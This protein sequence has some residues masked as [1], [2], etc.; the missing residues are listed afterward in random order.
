MYKPPEATRHHKPIKLLIFLPLR[1][2]LLCTLHYETPCRSCQPLLRLSFLSRVES[3]EHSKKMFEFENSEKIVLFKN[4]L[5]P[6]LTSDDL[7]RHFKSATVM[8][9]FILLYCFVG[10]K[11]YKKCFRKKQVFQIRLLCNLQLCIR[12]N[13]QKVETYFSW[14]SGS[15][16]GANCFNNKL[17]LY[18]IH[19]C[20]HR[21][22]HRIAIFGT[23][24]FQKILP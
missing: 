9:M 8:K 24:V 10:C 13:P 12:K 5:W 2:D 19:Q 20:A 17:I 1:A 18:K 16:Q 4:F 7:R 6:S 21:S 11:K 14:K 3:N 15:F 22:L 23:L